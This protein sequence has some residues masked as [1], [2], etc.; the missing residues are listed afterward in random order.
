MGTIVPAR[1][2]RGKTGGQTWRSSHSQRVQ[3]RW[4]DRATVKANG[5]RTLRS[6]AVLCFLRWPIVKQNFRSK[7]Q[8]QQPQAALVAQALTCTCFCTHFGTQTVTVFI[9]V[10]GTQQHTVRVACVGTHLVSQTVR[11]SVLVSQMQRVLQT[12]TWTC[13]QTVW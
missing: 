9:V 8:R 1:K 5:P 12:G 7:A 11:I 10:H 6:R 13:L 3:I 4:G 2:N